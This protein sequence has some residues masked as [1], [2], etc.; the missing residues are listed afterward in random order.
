[1]ILQTFTTFKVLLGCSER[2]VSSFIE[3]FYQEA[4]ILNKKI[5]KR[6]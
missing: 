1:M 4:L 5:V 3:K 6:S 2:P